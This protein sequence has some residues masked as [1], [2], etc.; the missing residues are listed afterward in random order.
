MPTLET[1]NL[2]TSEDEDGSNSKIAPGVYYIVNDQNKN[3][4]LDVAG[5]D[6]RTVL[7]APHPLYSGVSFIEIEY[8]LLFQHT[9]SMVATIR[10]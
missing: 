7:G 8:I 5:Y 4:V 10:R 1:P 3:M 6:F 9:G 2:S